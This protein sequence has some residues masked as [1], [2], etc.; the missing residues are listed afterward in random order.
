MK[1]C[2]NCHTPKSL[3]DFYKRAITPD[4]REA[5]CKVCRLAKN[6]TNWEKNQDAHREL[7]RKW[8]QD[9]K[10]LHLENS[11]EWYAENAARKLMTTNARDARCKLA[12]PDW[13]DKGIM[14]GFYIKA[15]RLSDETGIPHEVDHYYPLNGKTVSGLNVHTNLQVLTGVANR[16]K[17]NSMPTFN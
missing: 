16:R 2:T 15:K 13:N 3:E 4:G 6:K 14:L 11:K 1:T 5:W 8:Y 9:N 10:E 7:T 12:T 17:F